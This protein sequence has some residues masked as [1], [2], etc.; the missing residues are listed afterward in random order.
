[1]R[2]LVEESCGPAAGQQAAYGSYRKILTPEWIMSTG[3]GAAYFLYIFVNVL[4]KK[5]L[6]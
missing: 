6:C 3:I 4:Y 2:S 5:E 1:M